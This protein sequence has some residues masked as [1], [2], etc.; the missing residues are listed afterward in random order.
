MT[1]PN[2]KPGEQVVYRSR[3]GGDVGYVMPCIV[4]EDTPEFVVLF[5]PTG[6]VCKKRTG[7]RGGPTGRVMLPDGWDGGHEDVTWSGPPKLRFYAWGSAHSILRSWDSEADRAEGWY[8]NLEAP[9]TPTSIGFDTRDHILDITVSP[10]LSSW[11]W[12]DEDE[13]A[14]AVE[15]GKCDYTP[16]SA[17]AIRAE[18]ERALEKLERRHRPFGDDWHRW[19][20]DPRW[21]IPTLPEGWDVT[22]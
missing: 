15:V 3:P 11:A 14:W 2:R 5:Q 22:P 9:W 13:L 20:P 8:I 4:V 7:R 17:R 12:K 21:P 10:D 19:R 16:E 18:G 1:R 6:T